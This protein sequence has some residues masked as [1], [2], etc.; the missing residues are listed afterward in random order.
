VRDCPMYEDGV[1]VAQFNLRSDLA[2]GLLSCSEANWRVQSDHLSMGLYRIPYKDKTQILITQD[3]RTH[4]PAN[5][6][7]IWSVLESQ[8]KPNRIV[9]AASG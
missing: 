7:D 6:L 4:K 2:Q 9:A 3:H 1:F 5:R 8:D